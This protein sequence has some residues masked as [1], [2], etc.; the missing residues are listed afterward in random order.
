MRDGDRTEAQAVLGELCAMTAPVCPPDRYWP[1][2]SN[3]DRACSA[4]RYELCW[5]LD[6]RD[7]SEFEEN[8]A[9]AVHLTSVSGRHGEF[10]LLKAVS[11]HHAFASLGS[12][13]D[14]RLPGISS[15]DRNSLFVWGNPTLN[16]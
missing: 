10:L 13:C 15:D 12:L 5:G 9:S 16:L 14:F 8:E 2:D 4:V 6:H 11:I 3:G 7:L 1:S